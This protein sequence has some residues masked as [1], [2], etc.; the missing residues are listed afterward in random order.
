MKSWQVLGSV[1]LYFTGLLVFFSLERRD[2]RKRRASL[3]VDISAG[4]RLALICAALGFSTA[5]SPTTSGLSGWLAY[6]AVIVGSASD[7]AWIALVAAQR[8]L[9]FWRAL[10]ELTRRDR[11]A[12]RRLWTALI[13]KDEP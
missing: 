10:L 13:G 12:Q 5:A 7:G 2:H 1:P 9:G 4:G 6:A 11:Q 3:P 8:R